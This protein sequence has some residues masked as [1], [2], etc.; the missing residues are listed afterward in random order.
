[1]N[2]EVP[3]RVIDRGTDIRKE[4]KAIFEPQPVVVG[5][6]RQPQAVDVL[7]HDVRQTGIGGAAIEQPA[8]VRV[9][10]PGERLTLAAEARENEIGVHAR[11]HQLDRDSG[12]ILVVVA[13]GE[14]DRAHAASTK[15]ANQPV[16]ADADRLRLADQAMAWSVEERQERYLDVLEQLY[17]GISRQLVTSQFVNWHN[18]PLARGSYSFPAPG[19]VMSIGPILEQGLGRLHFAGEHTCYAFSGFMEGALDSGAAVAKRLA[20]R[21]G[22]VK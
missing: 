15:L 16:R 5:E 14:K 6:L 2:D 3:V 11:P 20:R 21:D 13:L 19:Q 1:M 4:V 12:V 9:L 10:Q 8:D 7:H 22:V 17:P 18:D